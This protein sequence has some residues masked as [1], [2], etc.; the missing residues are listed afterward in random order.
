[1]A[2]GPRASA[3]IRTASGLIAD[4]EPDAFG[5]RAFKGLPY[6]APPVGQL[7]WRA[8]Q[9]PAR[10]DGVCKA[11]RWG[12]RATQSRRLGDLDPLNDRMSEDCLYL[13]VWTPARSADERL[14]TMVWIHGGSNS[15]GAASQPEYDGANLA[16]KG[17]AIVSINY[18]LDVLGF[19]A[20]PEL[21]AELGV[22]SSGN[23]G[24]LDQIAALRWVSEN[25]AAFGGDPDNI[26][27]FG[28]S[29]GAFDISLLM[30]SPLTEGLFARAIGQSGGAMSRSPLTGPKPLE[31][32]ERE[33]LGFARRLGAERIGA[34]RALPAETLLAAAIANPIS[35]G[36]G[37][38]DGHV[39]PEH[40]AGI[41]AAGRQRPV[42]LLVGAN[43][44]EGTL[45]EPRI[46]SWGLGQP[47]FV[48]RVRA[49][50]G[51]QAEQ[52]L[53]HYP[54]GA[55]LAE[56][57]AAYARLVG[58]QI[59][60][61]GA[62]RWA[63]LAAASGRAP[64]YRYLFDRR[65]PGAPETSIYPLTAPGV[66]HFAEICY[67]FDNQHL[68]DWRW[69]AADRRLAQAMSSVLGQFRAHRRPQR[70]GIAALAALHGRRLRPVDAAR[71]RNR[72][73]RRGAGGARAI[74]VPR[75]VPTRGRATLGRIS[76]KC[77]AV[78]R[79]NPASSNDAKQRFIG[80]PTNP[81][82]GEG[83]R[84]AWPFPL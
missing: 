44:D 50:F 49:Q 17:V 29:A 61:L 32:G 66:Y 4:A 69:G 57:Q 52:A 58:D 78:F 77:R 21:T 33:G 23:Y 13:N 83:T 22:G 1:M 60:D 34:L 11:D 35:Y 53:A 19:L 14:P 73:A 67:V 48:E 70:R 80:E 56:D 63:E 47:S 72:G 8:P 16:R 7:R 46:A 42:P 20:H 27:V 41:F 18:R 62:W 40:P 74:G 5:V 65:P 84:L 68:R 81:W 10:R 6:A 76:E 43:R 75:R 79:K 25:I 38:V 82:L 36:F 12:P 9:P 30:A 64:V 3:P 2:S 54:P 31:L 37:V 39:A 26:T 45:F 28:E 59:I 15:I 24:L 71:R 51:A 55:T